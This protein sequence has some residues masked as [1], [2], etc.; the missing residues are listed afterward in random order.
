MNKS[1]A[2]LYLPLVQALV[3]GKTLQH[4]VSDGWRDMLYTDFSSDP[5]SYRIKPTPF[6]PKPEGM[7]WHNPDNL[8]GEQVGD[9]WRL[10]VHD[11]PAP[12][13]DVSESWGDV[14]KTWKT[15][16]D[17]FVGGRYSAGV[18]YRVPISTPFPDGSKIVDGKL[19]G[20]WVPR[21]K[22]G[23]RVRQVG[24]DAAWEVHEIMNE[25]Y[26]LYRLLPNGHSTC[27]RTDEQLEPAPWSLSRHIPGFRPLRDGE[28]WHR[29]DRW[30]EEWLS[31]GKRPL[32]YG[33]KVESGDE[34]RNIRDTSE[35]G[36]VASLPWIAG[37]D[38]GTT[39]AGDYK[40]GFYLRTC[41]SLPE[42]KKQVPWD[43]TSDFPKVPTI[44]IRSKNDY[45]DHM[46]IGFANSCAI[47]TASCGCQPILESIHLTQDG[48]K[49]MEWSEDRKD[50]QPCSKEAS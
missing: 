49:D 22:V 14:T 34:V 2:H 11:E 24:S 10:T 16:S 4:K 29:T 23:D 43:D 33:E 47:I 40:S 45:R 17:Q 19:V 28:E 31:R 44:W 7:E 20:P 15:R 37:V 3:D 27:W 42:P 30:R 8:T 48:F 21:F 18:T 39:V 46:V 25:G 41:R 1:N 5:E 26:E 50:W 38:T 36:D 12:N 9:G 6:P 13:P 35:W 32:L